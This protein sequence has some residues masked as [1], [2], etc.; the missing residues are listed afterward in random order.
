MGD[1]P[2]DALGRAARRV[3]MSGALS[4]GAGVGIERR[5]DRENPKFAVVS[6]GKDMVL[7]GPLAAV[8]RAFSIAG[9]MS[10]DGTPGGARSVADPS[11][12][13]R[14]YEL[15]S[16]ER[17]AR[18]VLDAHAP[19]NGFPPPAGSYAERRRA[20]AEETLRRVTL[21]RRRLLRQEKVAEA[22]AGKPGTN[23]TQVSPGARKKIDP[24]VRHYRKEAH[25]FTACVRDNTKRFGKDRAERMCAVVKDMGKATTKWRAREAACA[26]EMVEEAQ[27]RV[28]A[29]AGVV[30]GP[31]V[32]SLVLRA[33][34]ASADGTLAE[35]DESAALGESLL[36]DL[37]VIRTLGA[38]DAPWARVLSDPALE[39]AAAPRLAAAA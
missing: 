32:R 24:I 2:A 20:E 31:G 35:A 12:A 30:G 27:A 34:E 13:A 38:G 7:P 29:V 26:V 28:M 5:G 8:T 23:W 9:A 19:Q 11:R 36:E 3:A 17:R 1:H 4:L 37:V 6:N 39:R 22:E 10:Q 15:E 14:M 25:P 21:E 18:E 16:M 33:L